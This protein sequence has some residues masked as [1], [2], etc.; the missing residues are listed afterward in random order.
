VE[1]AEKLP[2]GLAV[3]LGG[4][5]MDDM[6]TMPLR[7]ACWGADTGWGAAKGMLGAAAMMG[8]GREP[9]ADG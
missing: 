4:G 1:N 3:E 6:A 2:A 7:F 8:G 5:E 9:V